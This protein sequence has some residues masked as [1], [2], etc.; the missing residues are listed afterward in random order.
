MN[1]RV[2]NLYKNKNT[3]ELA[4]LMRYDRGAKIGSLNIMLK[5]IQT[6]SIKHL[7]EREFHA[8]WLEY[9]DEAEL[10]ITFTQEE[11]AR[12][13]KSWGIDSNISPAEIKNRLIN[14]K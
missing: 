9:K 13:R 14:K 11:I 8:G 10:T 12:L 4:R 1:I 5:K 3:G 7:T 2:N 6:N